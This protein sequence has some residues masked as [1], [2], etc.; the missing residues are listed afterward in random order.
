MDSGG[1]PLKRKSRLSW[2]PKP[3]YMT[4]ISSTRTS[5]C[6]P[7]R[8]QSVGV[9]LPYERRSMKLDIIGTWKCSSRFF[10]NPWNNNWVRD[11]QNDSIFQIT[12]AFF[13]KSWYTKHTV[14][15]IANE[16]V[17][18]GKHSNPSY[19]SAW[20]VYYFTRWS[21]TF[22]HFLRFSRGTPA[23][24][25]ICAPMSCTIRSNSRAKKAYMVYPCALFLL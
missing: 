17:R 15:S 6:L 1:S 7:R 18:P 9:R 5:I 2:I 23:Q 16:Q 3:P 25:L 19:Q 12:L 11:R 20:W 8:K 22:R 10:I 14:S 24:K 21:N 4:E 13:R